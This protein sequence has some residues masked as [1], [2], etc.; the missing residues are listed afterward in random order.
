MICPKTEPVPR[1]EA[2]GVLR[3]ELA[4]AE[5]M[6]LKGAP[7][8]AGFLSL[9]KAGDFVEVDLASAAK[10]THWGTHNLVEVGHAP[11][12]NSASG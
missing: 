4:A 1:T 5:E 3:K 10:Q 8:G 2:F 6:L 9:L 7:R 12:E 11:E